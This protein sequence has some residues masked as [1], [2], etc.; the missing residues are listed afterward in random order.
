MMRFPA[1]DALSRASTVIEQ[2]KVVLR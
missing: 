1:N 2:Q